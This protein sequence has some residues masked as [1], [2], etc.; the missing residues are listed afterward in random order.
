MCAIWD[1]CFLGPMRVL[2]LVL[3]HVLVLKEGSREA[4]YKVQ[5]QVLV[6]ILLPTQVQTA[7][8]V[9]VIVLKGPCLDACSQCGTPSTRC[10][11]V[12]MMPER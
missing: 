5:V 8:M 9:T 10:T 11:I 12:A 1:G 3:A 2:V 4:S 6:M 7:V